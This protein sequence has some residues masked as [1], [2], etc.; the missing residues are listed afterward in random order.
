[1]F[2]L[3]R[4]TAV[5]GAKLTGGTSEDGRL[6]GVALDKSMGSGLVLGLSRVSATGAKVGLDGTTSIMK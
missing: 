2:G 5:A 3:S 6:A 1:M 4:V